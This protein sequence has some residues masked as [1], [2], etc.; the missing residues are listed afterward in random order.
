M[1]DANGGLLRYK[2]FVLFST[3]AKAA[4]MNHTLWTIET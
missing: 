3:S 2:T 4:E 1:G